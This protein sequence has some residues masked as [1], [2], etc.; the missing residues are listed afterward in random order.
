M[1]NDSDSGATF[2]G[3]RIE[4]DGGMEA[5][6]KAWNCGAEAWVGEP[7]PAGYSPLTGVLRARRYRQSVQHLNKKVQITLQHTPFLSKRMI[8]SFPLISLL[9]PINE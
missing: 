7:V 6:L 9:C 2:L 3:R 1:S 5:A 4:A 8:S